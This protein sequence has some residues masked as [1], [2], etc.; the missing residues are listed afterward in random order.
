MSAV[1]PAATLSERSKQPA[2]STDVP[3]SSIQMGC[4]IGSPGSIKGSVVKL[5]PEGL[6]RVARPEL[7]SPTWSDGVLPMDQTRAQTDYERYGGAGALR[8]LP[9]NRLGPE[10]APFGPS[11]A[12]AR[13]ISL[14]FTPRGPA[15]LPS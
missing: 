9:V 4:L 6:E 13:I 1:A 14:R 3:G 10:V 8:L 7:A 15:P 2:N 5:L 12:G 11:P